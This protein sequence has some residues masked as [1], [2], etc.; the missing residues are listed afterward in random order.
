MEQDNSGK[1]VS[2]CI[3]VPLVTVIIGFFTLIPIASL[4]EVR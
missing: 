2:D 3:D 1:S 4:L